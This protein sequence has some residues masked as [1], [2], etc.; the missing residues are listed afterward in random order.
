MNRR[1]GEDG[2][3]GGGARAWPGWLERNRGQG[4]LCVCRASLGTLMEAHS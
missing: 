1:N 4:E 3:G 2:R